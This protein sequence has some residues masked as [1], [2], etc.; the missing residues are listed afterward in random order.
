M[1]DGR[2]AGGSN[3]RGPP[4][5]YARPVIPTYV[6]P[7]VFG[8]SL[9]IDDSSNSDDGEKDVQTVKENEVITIPKNKSSPQSF[10]K[11]TAMVH[12]PGFRSEPSPETGTKFKDTKTGAELVFV[13]QSDDGTYVMMDEKAKAIAWYDKHNLILV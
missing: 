12:S 1:M 9:F 3:M 8:R 13:T 6:N 7:S 4:R 11:D 2:A 5:K 10:K